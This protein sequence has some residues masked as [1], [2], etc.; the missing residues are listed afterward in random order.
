M[1]K[2]LLVTDREEVIGAFHEVQNLQDMMFAPLTIIPDPQAAIDYMACNAVDAVGYSMRHADVSSLHQYL[3]DQRPSLPVFVTHHQGEALVHELQRVRRFLDS[4]H[5][6]YADG[7]YNEQAVL[8]YLR[9]E[10]MHQLLAH[11]IASPDELLTR[12]KLVRGDLSVDQPALLFDFDMPQGE[13]Y[14]SG[15]WHYGRE[16]LESALRNHFFGRDADAIVYGV[17]VLAPRHIR[18][19]AVQRY[20][21]TP[22]GKDSLMPLV[23]ER[24]QQAVTGIKE[25]LDLE[26]NLQRYSVLE[27]IRELT[28][29]S[30]EDTNDDPNT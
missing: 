10:L 25:Y 2:L 18:V 14:L 8:E 17:A 26:L 6:D 28:G 29:A 13:V 1:Y 7:E 20:E 30:P 16:R 15:R 22:L 9:D 11:E 4:L 27:G 19:L 12:L 23:E 21:T 3:V 24:V 5:G